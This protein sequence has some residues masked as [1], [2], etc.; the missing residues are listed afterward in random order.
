MSMIYTNDLSLDKKRIRT[1]L[2]ITLSITLVLFY[3]SY[4]IAPFAIIGMVLSSLLFYVVLRVYLHL[5]Q[6]KPNKIN[7]F[8]KICSKSIPAILLLPFLFLKDDYGLFIVGVMLGLL[9]NVFFAEI[10]T[11]SEV[12]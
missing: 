11:M 12:I 4:N 10:K 9:A 8:G 5:L 7:W 3:F 2:T 6:N 1:A